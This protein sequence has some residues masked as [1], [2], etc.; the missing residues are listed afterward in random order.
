MAPEG[1]VAIWDYEQRRLLHS[2][3]DASGPLLW[4]ET[5]S[6]VLAVVNHAGTL[7]RWDA[8]TGTRIQAFLAT[9][10]RQ[11]DI[12]NRKVGAIT[13]RGVRGV[14]SSRLY[15]I[16]VFDPADG[17][18]LWESPW[19]WLGG[20][21]GLALSADGRFVASGD[22][23][24]IRFANTAH[25]EAC[26]LLGGHSN[27][28]EG[29]AFIGASSNLVSCGRD[30][31]LL[32]WERKPRFAITFSPDTNGMRSFAPELVLSADQRFCA[33]N[34]EVR[35]L[36]GGKPVRS[37]ADAFLGFSPTSEE[38]VTESDGELRVWKCADSGTNTSRVFPRPAAFPASS[39][40]P[41]RLSPDG[42]FLACRDNWSTNI[43]VFQA[44]TGHLLASAADH[45]LPAWL[46]DQTMFGVQFLPASHRLLVETS[47]GGA[48]WDWQARS[49]GLWI[50]LPGEPCGVSLDGRWLA[51]LDE[52]RRL[53]LVETEA[54][55]KVGSELRGHSDRISAVAF[56]HDGRTLASLDARDELRLWKLP[57]GRLVGV[58]KVAAGSLGNLVFA[59]DDQ[60]LYVTGDLGVEVLEA[61]RTSQIVN[62]PPL[63]KPHVLPVPSD[64]IWAR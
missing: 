59:P 25:L 58:K 49:N 5:N 48:I 2:F 46:E 31:R 20:R 12:I 38:Y 32:L 52:S 44:R 11:G 24:R 6:T 9:P 4:W 47:N 50:R 57:E 27:D 40:L 42:C 21:E 61:P 41:M 29:I 26:E 54:S 23:E 45:P 17:R 8:V 36:P 63:A 62:Q 7:Q 3:P 51:L 35:S 53:T 10:S 22:L 19:S 28:V 55:Q 13:A 56:S 15:E 18:I 34:G 30:G 39:R 43:L 14:L 64:S 33:V 1:R 16:S 37:Y 60:R